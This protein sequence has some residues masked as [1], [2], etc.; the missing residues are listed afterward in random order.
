MPLLAKGNR[1]DIRKKVL[2]F[3]HYRRKIKESPRYFHQVLSDGKVIGL[4][5]NHE[6]DDRKPSSFDG[7]KPILGFAVLFL[8]PG[9]TEAGQIKG[10]IAN[11]LGMISSLGEVMQT[12]PFF[13]F[14]SFVFIHL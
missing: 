13:W 2:G 3:W 14:C 6:S 11:M 4:H 8:A 9:R 12:L 10:R 5:V 7:L 1:P